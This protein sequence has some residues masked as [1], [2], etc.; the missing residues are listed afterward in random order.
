MKFWK[1]GVMAVGASMLWPLGAGAES[2]NDQAAVGTG[3]SASARVDFQVNMPE[4]LRFRVGT[5]GVTIDMVEFDLL[6]HVTGG[7]EVGDGTPIDGT[8][9]Q[10]GAGDVEVQVVS[11]AGQITITEANDGAGDGLEATDGPTGGSTY[12]PYAEID[13]QSADV[14]NLPAPALSNA[15][16]NTAVVALSDGGRTNRQTTWTYKY[17]NTDVYDAGTYTGRVT[18]TAASP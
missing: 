7:G 18:Y 1:A 11:N 14:A 10:L 3:V 16:G 2:N 12:I 5:A 8:G 15:G 9:G 6:A 17:Q 13:S 4:F